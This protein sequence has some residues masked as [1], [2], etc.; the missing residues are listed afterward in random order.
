MGFISAMLLGAAAARQL[1]PT[2]PMIRENL[3][4]IGSYQR[5]IQNSEVPTTFEIPYVVPA[6]DEATFIVFASSDKINREEQEIRKSVKSANAGEAQVDVEIMFKITYESFYSGAGLAGNVVPETVAKLENGHLKIFDNAGAKVSGYYWSIVKSRVNE[7]FEAGEPLN[8]DSAIDLRTVESCQ[9]KV[10]WDEPMDMEKYGFS[11]NSGKLSFNS[12]G[13]YTNDVFATCSFPADPPFMLKWSDDRVGESGVNFI[14]ATV[15][16]DGL[17]IDSRLTCEVEDDYVTY[18][19]DQCEFQNFVTRGDVMGPPMI[20]DYAESANIISSEQVWNY[21]SD[22]DEKQSVSFIC[23]EMFNAELVKL[24]SPN[25]VS[26]SPLPVLTQASNQLP[27]GVEN[28][29][30]EQAD[31]DGDF[32]YHTTFRG[33][34][35]SVHMEN[36]ALGV[37]E[38]RCEYETVDKRVLGFSRPHIVV[39]HN[40][41]YED[42]I[43]V[44]GV[45][46]AVVNTETM[47]V[48]Q[49]EKDVV[50]ATCMQRTSGKPAAVSMVFNTDKLIARIPAPPTEQHFIN[51][52]TPITAQFDQATVSC[53]YTYM[54]NAEEVT[55]STDLEGVLKVAFRPRDMA[56]LK[57]EEIISCSASVSSLDSVTATLNINENVPKSLDVAKWNLTQEFTEGEVNSGKFYGLYCT[58]QS[59]I[60]ADE[61][62]VSYTYGATDPP[63]EPNQ[64]LEVNVVG[65]V[66]FC[67]AG[68]IAV[69]AICCLM[70]KSEPKAEKAKYEIADQMDDEDPLHAEEITEESDQFTDEKV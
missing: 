26:S 13:F 43:E 59:T 29:E 12:V 61:T 45:W 24:V 56:I 40:N 31:H 21:V 6:E 49:S 17:K 34:E 9:M 39:K 35:I 60:F 52:A 2:F 32:H 23:P 54:K 25:F 48:S 63:E 33:Y 18:N 27:E 7:T 11:K 44:V 69:I 58:Y 3:P 20:S 51:V 66:L 70:P 15:P 50:V 10:Q 42:D 19:S 62:F 5:V 64:N 41:V 67:L 8:F 1:G 65:P 55:E 68:A 36:Q 47:V 46:G 38:F 30:D 57:D 14:S 37:Y 22:E 53:E 28:E 4:K 16:E